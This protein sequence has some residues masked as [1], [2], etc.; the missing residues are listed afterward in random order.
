MEGIPED[1]FLGKSAETSHY[2]N[3]ESRHKNTTKSWGKLSSQDQQN[4]QPS[5]M[6]PVSAGLTQ[7]V[8]GGNVNDLS[9]QQLAA[10]A[11]ASPGKEEEGAAKVVSYSALYTT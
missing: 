5:V 9:L 4:Q 1:Y 7:A 10:A 8:G 2:T 6:T 3:H 11:P